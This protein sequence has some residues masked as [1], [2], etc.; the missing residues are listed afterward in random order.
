MFT[1]RELPV[2]KPP[3]ESIVWHRMVN[4]PRKAGDLPRE[5]ARLL[6]RL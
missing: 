1:E 2:L 3:S 6:E 4:C 5:A